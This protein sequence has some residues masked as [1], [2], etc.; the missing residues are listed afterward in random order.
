MAIKDSDKAEVLAKF[1]SSVFTQEPPGEL[2]DFDNRTLNY[3]FEEIKCNAQ[4]VEKLL[5]NL[6]ESKSQGP[7]KMHPRVLKEL[8]IY[9]LTFGGHI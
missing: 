8:R 1:F 3:P 9:Q 2:P 7:D 6:N 4:V 5:G